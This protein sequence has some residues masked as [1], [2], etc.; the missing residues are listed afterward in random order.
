[1]SV[2]QW[3]AAITKSMRST[4]SYTR[5]ARIRAA[6]S[7][8]ASAQRQCKLTVVMWAEQRSKSTRCT[9]ARSMRTP[10]MP[11]NSSSLQ[12]LRSVQGAPTSWRARAP[13]LLMRSQ[14]WG[15]R[16]VRSEMDP[17]IS[18]RA[19]IIMRRP[20]AGLSTWAVRVASSRL[21]SP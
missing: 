21:S 2:C 7:S 8:T 1:M 3:S 6:R 16:T 11:G 19:L 10:S 15:T 17:S 4:V 12:T 13:I 9:T 18:R 5:L 14:L 20:H